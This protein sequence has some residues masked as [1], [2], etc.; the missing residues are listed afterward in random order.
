MLTRPSRLAAL[1]VAALLAAPAAAQTDKP[2]VSEETA[3]Y[4]IEAKLP[5]L[6]AGE[7]KLSHRI[8][9]HLAR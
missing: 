7:P 9:A 2:D 8:R 4:T 3:A 5:D 1:L 6:P